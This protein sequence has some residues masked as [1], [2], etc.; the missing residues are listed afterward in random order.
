MCSPI[1]YVVP[2]FLFLATAVAL[3]PAA[4]AGRPCGTF[5]IVPTPDPGSSSNALIGVAAVGDGTA[6]A[7]GSQSG[8]GTT[9]LILYYDGAGWSE[10]DI[11]A[12]AEGISFGAI[13]NT[14]EGEVWMVGT[15]PHTVYEVEVIWLRARDGAIDRVDSF[16]QGGG[17]VDVSAS[18]AD[19]VWGVSGGMWSTDQGGYANR[20]NGTDWETMQLPAPY[21]YRND[22]QGIFAAGPDDVWI[23]GLGGASKNHWE[24]YVQHWNGTSWERVPTPVDGQD[25]IFFES[26]DGSGPDDIWIS[27]HVNYVED[28]LLHW[29]GSSWSRHAGLARPEP[30]EDVAAP[31]P[32]NAWASP[33]SQ[34]PGTPFFRFD[35]ESW[36]EGSVVEVPGAQTVNWRDLSRAG[37][38]EVWSAGSYHDGTT[39]HT[40]VARMVGTALTVGRSAS[41]AGPDE[42]HLSWTELPGIPAY[43]VVSGD[44]RT[45]LGAAG[46]YSAATTECHADNHP[47]TEMTIVDAVAAGEAHW[48]LTRGESS[49]G[50]LSYD[51]GDAG[52]AASRDTGI[53]AAVGACPP[54]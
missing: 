18:A 4:L 6:W 41:E 50:P 53:E 52:Q 28:L 42:T 37:D 46:D 22:P 30:L 25:L 20:F 38:C 35:G 29:D 8:N 26:I 7:V 43:D 48:Y 33:Y 12:E 34:T 44:L 13:G 49:S 23:V 16:T 10:V 5:A 1:R 19:N 3:L 45:L 47:G 39:H 36:V 54:G 40:L 11:P 51:A 15:R 31:A 21:G 9:G 14:P 2:V 24:G 27:G 32:D 17:P